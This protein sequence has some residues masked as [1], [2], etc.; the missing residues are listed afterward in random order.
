MSTPSSS[1]SGA[2]VAAGNV[3][4]V[5]RFRPSSEREEREGGTQCVSFPSDESVELDA[6]GNK[7]LFTF[8]RC[9]DPESSQMNVFQEIKPVVLD[10]MQGYNSTML[11]YGQTGSGK[12]HTMEGTDLHDE[13]MRGV[14]PR[15]VD[16]LFACVAEA[17]THLEFELR[18]SYIEIYMERV[19]DLLDSFRT[20]VNLQIREDPERGVY[21]SGCQ[22][23]YVTSA[24]ELLQVMEAGKENRAVAATGMNTGSSRSHS[25]FIIAVSQ[26]DTRTQAVRTGTLHLVDLAGS[27]VQ[28][29]TF[30]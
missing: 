7:H 4:V 15:A 18:V 23:E 22:E 9:L 25:V 30:P 19:R 2:N 6:N 11:A 3:R 12:T 24:Q 28:Y 21:V 16:E 5:C 14:I 10:V 1:T 8:D 17:D 26:R 13:N 20:R 29:C 27:E